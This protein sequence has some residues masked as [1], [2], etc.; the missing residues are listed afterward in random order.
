[1][2]KHVDFSTVESVDEGLALNES[3]ISTD[4]VALTFMVDS[5]SPVA[6][7]KFEGFETVDDAKEYIENL[8]ETLPLLLFN[9][10]RVH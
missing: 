3:F 7:V 9:S 8:Q 6:Y 10:I 2:K 4:T 5:E 1:M